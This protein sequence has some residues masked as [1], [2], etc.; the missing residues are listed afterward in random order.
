MIHNIKNVL[1]IIETAIENKQIP[2][3]H[4]PTAKFIQWLIESNSSI[5]F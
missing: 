2:E 4:I 1:S 5:N 3:D